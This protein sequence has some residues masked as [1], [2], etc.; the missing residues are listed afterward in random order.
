MDLMEQFENATQDVK[1]L[2]SKPSVENMLKLYAFYK[3]ATAGDVN[4]KRPGMLNLAGRSKY[5]AWGKIKGMSAEEAKKSYI[6]LVKTLE[7][8]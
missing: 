5:D 7:N 4:G 1:K 2:A 8:A 6:N 3:Q